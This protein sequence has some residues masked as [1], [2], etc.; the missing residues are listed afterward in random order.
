MTSKGIGLTKPQNTRAYPKAIVFTEENINSSQGTGIALLRHFKHYPQ[1]N[2]LN[3]FRMNFKEGG[4]AF[5][6]ALHL[7]KSNPV[8]D[9]LQWLDAHSFRPNIMYSTFYSIEGFRLINKLMCVTHL[10]L[11]V[12]QHFFDYF[13]E[14]KSLIESEIR[15][16]SPF[17]SEVWALNPTIAGCISKVLGRE[18]PTVKIFHYEIS[19]NNYK[20]EHQEFGP[21]FKS[22]MLGNIWLAPL[23]DD[24]RKAWNWI[25]KS[26]GNISPIHWYCHPG[27]I[28][29]L[30][31]RGF[32][33]GNEI[34]YQGFVPEDELQVRLKNADMAII[35]FNR[36]KFP[37]NNYARYSIPSRITEIA[38]A[39]LPMFFAAGPN[40]DV[41][42]FVENTGIG[43]C[44]PPVDEII[45]RESLLAFIKDRDLRE[46]CGV[47]ARKLAERE[48]DINKYR[49]FLYG[50]LMEIAKNPKPDKENITH[51]NSSHHRLMRADRL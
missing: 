37:E 27:R 42:D 22:V 24:I 32:K 8:R 1:E 7:S 45:F 11:P 15:E 12:I 6:N 35:P 38:N 44:S 30:E 33:I 31:S 40:T 3:I 20:H 25:G 16:L 10:K 43:I 51:G 23:L 18:I 4:I 49:D 5:K 36:E 47:C 19:D 39:G 50:K 46:K 13:E 29:F 41:W 9:I 26:I 14:D 28:K 48:F 34:A 17:F 2:L 21:E